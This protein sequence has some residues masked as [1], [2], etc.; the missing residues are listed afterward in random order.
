MLILLPLAWTWL[1]QVTAG[2]YVMPGMVIGPA[3]VAGS[4]V[5]L[6]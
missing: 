4:V 6:R 5:E 2:S 1:V 3:R